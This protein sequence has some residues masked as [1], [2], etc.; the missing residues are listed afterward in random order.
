MSLTDEG[1]YGP[2]QL[3]MLEVIWG[4]GY[5]SPGG[6]DEIDQI[7]GELDLSGKRVLDIGCGSGGA[8]FHI[9]E[10][11]NAEEAVGF[12]V[13]PLVIE[14]AKTA[15]LEKGLSEKALFK[16]IIPGQLGVDDSSFDAIFSK[17]AFIHIPNKIELITDIHRVL[18]PGGYLAVGDWMR[19]D[20]NPPSLQMQEYIAAEGLDFYMCS[21]DKYREILESKGFKIISMTDRNEW[22]LEK[23]KKEVADIEGPLWNQVVEAIGIEEGEYALDIWKKLLGVVEKGEH[24]P[25]NFRALKL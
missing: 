4:K 16:S 2:K 8:V 10:K 22:Y 23:V 20:E 1:H 25:G 3:N 15:A 14:Q 21:L 18:K 13:E 19:N 6:S 7:I 24:R 5:L 12:D 9:L 11:H 17:E